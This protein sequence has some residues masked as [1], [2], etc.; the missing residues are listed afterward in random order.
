MLLSYKL[1]F[2]N[3]CPRSERSERGG[4]FQLPRACRSVGKNAYWKR[5]SSQQNF[6]LFFHDPRFTNIANCNYYTKSIIFTWRTLLD[7]AASLFTDLHWVRGTNIG[8]RNRKYQNSSSWSV[9]SISN[10]TLKLHFNFYMA[11]FFFIFWEVEQI[12]W[13]ST[14][15]WLHL[16]LLRSCWTDYIGAA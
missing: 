15:K 10:D 11:S 1:F 7:F 13:W 4:I 3:N 6:R 2:V 9:Y 8:V 14:E 16:H 12:S 5:I